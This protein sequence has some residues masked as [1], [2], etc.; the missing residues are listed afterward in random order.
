[1]SE[2]VIVGDYS[3]VIFFKALGMDTI[4]VD[5]IKEGLESVGKY[6]RTK[7]YKIIFV[8]EDYYKDIKKELEDTGSVVIP[9]PSPRGRKGTGLQELKESV[10]RAIGIDIFRD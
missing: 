2:I 4:A 7:S 9:I 1:M 10:E 5:R 3:T 8:I 6:L